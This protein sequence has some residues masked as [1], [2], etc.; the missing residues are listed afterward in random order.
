M[1][2]FAFYITVLGKEISRLDADD[3]DEIEKIGN[4]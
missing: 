4:K 1:Y 3:V 2:K